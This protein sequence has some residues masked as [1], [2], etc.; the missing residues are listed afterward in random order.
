MNYMYQLCAQQMSILVRLVATCNMSAQFNTNSLELVRPDPPVR[1]LQLLVC[2]NVTAVL[3]EESER[4]SW[5]VEHST[6]LPRVKQVDHV[7]PQVTL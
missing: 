5:E 4:V 3:K 1:Q 7:E 2:L 6:G